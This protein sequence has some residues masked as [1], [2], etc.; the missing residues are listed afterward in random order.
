V[1]FSVITITFNAEKYL[2]EALTSVILQQGVPF[3]HLVW[4][5]GSKDQTL[6]IA[7]SFDGIKIIEGKDKGIA[8]AM[9]QAAAVALGD[10]LLY[11]HADDQLAHPH[12]LLMIDRMLRLHPR[13]EWLYGRANIIDEKGVIL[14]T[15]PFEPYSARR[16]RKYN[17]ITHPATAVARS[18]F[19]KVGGFQKHLRYCMDYDLWLRLAAK[20]YS[21]LA[22]PTVVAYFRQHAQSLS[23]SAPLHVAD[24]AYQVR[25]N[26]VTSFYERIR[27][28]QIWK[29]RR[30]KY[31]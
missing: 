7:R 17:Y 31:Q 6:E 12:A 13:C 1:R 23:T 29:K 15:T 9:N 24:E 20:G 28:Y 19:H 27:S 11:I 21:A 10:F 22:L 26:Y 2:H 5:G 18:L 8:D 4:D 25:N 16:L 3:E 30:K 14:R